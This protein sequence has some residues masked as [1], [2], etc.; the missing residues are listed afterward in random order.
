MSSG[1]L[2]MR[3]AQWRLI[4]APIIWQTMAG[5]GSRQRHVTV[6]PLKLAQH[7]PHPMRNLH[8]HSKQHARQPLG[9]AQGS[10]CAG[11]LQVDRWGMSSGYDF[12]TVVIQPGVG[13]VGQGRA[14]AEGAG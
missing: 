7:P 6:S 8:T 9:A 14:V 10:T 1:F 11:D 12:S 13:R 5:K 2:L 4:T 3:P